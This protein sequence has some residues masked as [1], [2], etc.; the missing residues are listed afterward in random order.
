MNVITK[1]DEC[2]NKATYGRTLIIGGSLE[3]LGA[4]L[5]CA[6]SCLKSGVGYVSLGVEKKTYPYYAGKIPEVIYEI[7]DKF[8]DKKVLERVVKK[9]DSIVFG[10]GIENSKRSQKTLK[11]LLENYEKRLLIDATGLTILKEIGLD[12]LIK[13]KAQ[14]VLTP[15]MKEFSILFDMNIKNKVAN[16]F[17][18]ETKKI[19]KKYHIV[20][21][22]KDAKCV[23]TDGV[24]YFVVTSGN[25]SLAHAGTGDVVAGFI[26]GLL[27]YS[28]DELINIAFYGH[29]LVSL[30]AHYVSKEKS[31]HSIQPTDIIN[32]LPY[33]LKKERL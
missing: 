23:V 6:S 11:Y 21:V 19:A 3:F 4:V 7:F 29:D 1:R 31:N 9:Y 24:R 27:A 13:S 33:T 25:S 15:H 8:G 26:G 30:S 16:D 17:M 28:K 5:L 10:N 14:I 18:L 22:L 20:L 32:Q 2:A 12:L